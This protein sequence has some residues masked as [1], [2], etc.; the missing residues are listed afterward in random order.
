MAAE[1][2]PILGISL[3]W[4]LGEDAWNT[5][6][7]ASL[8]KLGVVIQCAVIARQDAPPGGTPDN[9]ALYL[10]GATGSGL[11]AGEDHKLAYY[12]DPLAAGGDKWVFYACNEGFRVYDKA[13]GYFLTADASGEFIPSRYLRPCNAA[14]T[15]PVFRDSTDPTKTVKI[16][17]SG[18]T[19]GN[20]RTWTIQ[21]K[22]I[23]P[24]SAA[25]DT[26]SGDLDMGDNQII[27]P[28][29]KDIAK[30]AVV[31]E[32]PSSL[33][34]AVANVYH[35]TLTDN[36]SPTFS[37]PPASGACGEMIVMVKQAAAGG[38]TIDWGSVVWQGASAPTMTATANK[39]DIYK[40]IS[41]DGG[42]TIYGQ[43]I[44]QN[45]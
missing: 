3:R 33:D 25:G 4:N 2:H 24:M 40:F 6:M 18:I 12:D 7:D 17:A 14:S 5:G 13:N 34:F 9:G 45:Y 19:T 10:V 32:E 29:L 37:N 23:T 35:V 27:R 15:V 30:T 20:D 21:D 28:K 43:V 11:W 31:G 39:V 16:D 41:V 1:T 36:W 42:T 8:L 44:G 38:K 22:D 26:M